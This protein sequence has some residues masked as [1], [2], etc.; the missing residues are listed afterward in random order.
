MT[1][2]AVILKTIEST[3][4]ENYDHDVLMRDYDA[5][6]YFLISSSKYFDAL[7]CD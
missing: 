6:R 1:V 4:Q 2:K 3:T 5:F 7:K